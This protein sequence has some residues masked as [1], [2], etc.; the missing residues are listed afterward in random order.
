MNAKLTDFLRN[1]EERGVTPTGDIICDGNKHRI[2]IFGDKRGTLNGEYRFNGTRGYFKCYKRNIFVRH[3]P[4]DKS[5]LSDRD[6]RNYRKELEY[7]RKQTLLEEQ[8]SARKAA[9]FANAIVDRSRPVDSHTYI[10]NKKIK[11]YS[12]KLYKRFLVMPLQD[13]NGKVHTLQY[14]FPNGQKRFLKNGR[15]KGHFHLIGGQFE[16]EIVITEGYATAASIHESTSKTCAVAV[17]ASNL[18]SV[19]KNLRKRLPNIKIIIA[20]DNDYSS[21]SANIGICAAKKAARAVAGFY[22]VP[23]LNDNPRQKCDFNDVFVN[24]GAQTVVT[25]LMELKL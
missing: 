19:A 17:S 10:R 6:L 7:K 5:D 16:N 21:Q 13:I 25:Q 15:I 3:D 9:K 22:C 23:C 18:M 24:E 20:A 8:A 4:I 2:H 1:I 11:P 14:I 12:L